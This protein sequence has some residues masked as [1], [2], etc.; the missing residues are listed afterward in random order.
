[1]YVVSLDAQ[2]QSFVMCRTYDDENLV[3]G[4]GSFLTNTKKKKK[5]RKK[6]KKEKGGRSKQ[7]FWYYV[8]FWIT[9]CIELYKDVQTVYLYRQDICVVQQI[10]VQYKKN[11]VYL[12]IGR[13][14]V[15]LIF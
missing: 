6:R 8:K 14:F 10:R 4:G 12:Y 9:Y 2:A 7:W 3:D 13:K 5:K 1:M 15:E 11:Q